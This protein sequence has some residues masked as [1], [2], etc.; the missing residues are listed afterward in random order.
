[1]SKR[2]DKI[3][4]FDLELTCWDSKEEQKDQVSEIIEIGACNLIVETLEI[5][6]KKS[7]I[8]KPRNSTISNYCTDLTTITQEQVNKGI[9]FIDA[10][11][12]FR[13]DF[14]TKNRVY[15]TWG[16]GDKFRLQDDCIRNNI[17]YFFNAQHIDVSTLFLIK[18][19]QKKNI[20]LEKALKMLNLNFEGTQ[21]RACDDAFNTAKILKWI[22]FNEN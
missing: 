14:G 10:C 16:D 18:T 17:P 11:N 22:L 20:N 13:N 2:L 12:K 6:D 3:I 19:K 8:I 5:I 21:H 7:Y 15:A 1:M 9:P 4:V